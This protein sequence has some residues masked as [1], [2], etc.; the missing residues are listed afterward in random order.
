MR[1]VLYVNWGTPDKEYTFK[2][3]AKKGLSIY[4]ATFEN[5]PDW[6]KSYVPASNIIITNT[7]DSDVLISDVAKYMKNTKTEFDAV[8][9]FFE[10]NIIQTAD[11]AGALNKT[12]LSAGSARRS[13]ANKLL[14]R[15]NC[16]RNGIPTPQFSPFNNLDE[17]LQ[18]LKKFQS[19]V[20][21]KA[22]RSG[23][24]YGVM[25]VEGETRHQ[26]KDDFTRKYK[27]AKRQLNANFDEWMEHYQPYKSYFLI[28][29]YLDGTVFSCD[30]LIQ[31]GKI[32]FSTITEYETTSGPHLLQNATF[33]PARFSLAVKKKC[34]QA[35]FEVIEVLG[36][37]NC[38]F[39]IEMKLTT[40]GP[41]LL[42]AA[43]RLPGGKILDS[44]REIYGIDLA[45]LFID[46]LMGKKLVKK[47]SRS[48]G[49]IMIEAVYTDETGLITQVKNPDEVN[50]PGFTLLSY[51]DINK[52]TAPVMG[53]PPMYFYYQ[54]KT[55]N[56][57]NIEKLRKKIK[58]LFVIKVEKNWLYWVG[59]FRH[60]FSL[61]KILLLIIIL[62]EIF[63]G[64]FILNKAYLAKVKQDKFMGVA[65]IDEK[66]LI[67]DGE[68][69]LKYFFEPKANEVIEDH[70]DWL[71]KKAVYKI[72]GDTLNERFEYDVSKLKSSFRVITIGDSHTFGHFI[73]TSQNYPERIEDQ[74][75]F[76]NKN[77]S[78]CRDSKTVEV[79]NLGMMG[80]DV[81]YTIHRY[82]TRGEKYDPDLIIWFI[83]DDDISQILEQMSPRIKFYKEE[84][85]KKNPDF[86]DDPVIRYEV[87]DKA[88]AELET[89][90]GLD[91]II[92]YNDTLIRD[93]LLNLNIP[94][95]FITYD[96]EQM[97]RMLLDSYTKLF[98]NTHVFSE[99]AYDDI[100]RLPDDHPSSLGYSNLSNKLVDYLAS[101]QSW[102]CKN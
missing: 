97:T 43:A 7:Y 47:Q 21:I 82:K 61:K 100:D 69:S 34:S 24:S 94:I 28:E 50:I 15:L 85:A 92:N 88:T 16:H 83:K 78:F 70:P 10:M 49:C 11:L 2:A 35:A 62:I 66:L 41:I 23:H 53:I 57:R 55:K 58:K 18:S 8:L 5:Y 32:V 64:V 40:E 30:G 76:L 19:P 51:I 65:S 59:K 84:L 74:L 25:K 93:F 38:G 89:V 46:L 99:L 17:G 81:E 27:L 68:S 96:D 1:N 77:N 102:F 12:F 80:Y 73:S 48:S 33:I 42:E 13:S 4:L 3:A 79:I 63:V 71:E 98:T 52:S 6:I 39:H 29:E 26:F 36:F 22:V 60:K 87:W 14:M 91:K 9:T 101:N 44:Y 90:F 95:V 31:D 67:R 54:L 45:S 20:V 37:D 72:N 86:L 75:R 56:W